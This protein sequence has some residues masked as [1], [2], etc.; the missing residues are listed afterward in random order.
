[1]HITKITLIN[2]RCFENLNIDLSKQGGAQNWLVMVGDNNSGKTSILRSLSMGLCDKTGASSLLQDT[3]GDWIRSGE[4]KADIIIDLCD[5]GNIFRIETSIHKSYSGL[6]EVGQITHPE[7]FPWD[8]IFV[9]GYGANRSIMGSESYDKY[10]SPDALYTLFNY[11][12]PLLNPELMFLRLLRK[13]FEENE[14]YEWLAEILMLEKE[15]IRLDESGIKVKRGEN[16]YYLGSMGDGYEAMTTLF[17][18]LFGWALLAGLG[19]KKNMI[20]GIVLID[21]LEQHLHPRWQKNIIKL[22]HKVF[23]QVQFITTTHSALCAIG[24]TNL[25]D[26]ECSLLMLSHE[27]DHVVGSK[28]IYPPRHQRADQ[29]L[30]GY[31]FGL[32]TSGDD[33]IEEALHKYAE[34]GSRPKRSEAEEKEFQSL[35]EYLGRTIGAPESE[36][37]KEFTEAV[38][39]VLRKRRKG[40]LAEL[41]DDERRVDLEILHHLRKLIGEENN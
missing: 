5:D 23:P 35:K 25:S 29:V 17:F 39:E 26:T 2:V 19:D 24:T 41:P 33:A 4:N 38:R 20:S 28:R 6:E 15:S 18:D 34:L 16:Y 1:M 3:Y 13:G 31:L 11:D 40:G 37:E 14:L 30:T 8:K 7:E 9:C 27:D 12:Y 10:S 22:L 32:P 36:H 21:E